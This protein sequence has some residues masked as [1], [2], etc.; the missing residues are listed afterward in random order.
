MAETVKIDI[1]HGRS[2]LSLSSRLSSSIGRNLIKDLIEFPIK[3]FS[4]AGNGMIREVTRDARLWRECSSRKIIVL[5]GLIP[6]LLDRHEQSGVE[7]KVIDHRRFRKR[8]ILSQTVLRNSS[9]DEREFLLAIKN[10]PLGQIEVSKRDE[11]VQR[12]LEIAHA[13]PAA[14]ILVRASRK[15]DANNLCNK[16]RL[17]DPEL[18]ASVKPPGYW[19]AKPSRILFTCGALNGGCESKDW[20]II[21]LPDPAK[22]VKK[23]FFGSMRIFRDY[24]YRCYSFIS[25]SISLCPPESLLLEAIS[26]RIIYSNVSHETAVQVLWQKPPSA[27][28]SGIKKRC[29]E[30]KQKSYWKNNRRNDFIAGVARAF[31]TNNTKKLKKYGVPFHQGKPHFTNP[32]TPKVVILVESREAGHELQKRL[33]DWEFQSNGNGN[34]DNKQITRPEKLIITATWAAQYGIEADVLIYAAGGQGIGA[35]QSTIGESETR[36]YQAPSVVIDLADEFDKIA[37]EDVRDRRKGYRERGWKQPEQG[38]SSTS[39]KSTKVSVAQGA[40]P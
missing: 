4:C 17:E 11:I 8:Q 32:N 12:T 7:V 22:A 3:E 40:T 27:P 37:E 34:V 35:L 14:K 19:P 9:G 38:L 25:P 16:L 21:L 20:D 1:R 33:P 15:V 2:R 24:P 10:N 30:W 6:A 26:G 31:V 13:F 36:P 23:G 28:A 18:D 5:T 29:L 39:G